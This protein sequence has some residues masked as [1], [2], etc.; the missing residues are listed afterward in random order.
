[1][2]VVTTPAFLTTRAGTTFPVA[3]PLTAILTDARGPMAGVPVTF[4]LPITGARATFPGGTSSVTVNTGSDGLA[5]AQTAMADPTVGAFAATIST[6]GATSTAVPMAAQY[7]LT[8][9]LPPFSGSQLRVTSATGTTPLKTSALLA[10]NTRLSDLAATA[11]VS[12]DRLQVRWRQVVPAGTTPPPWTTRAISTRYDTDMDFFQADLKASTLGWVK[13][14]TYEVN[15]RLLPAT[16]DP[17]PV[18]DALQ[19][20]FDLGSRS[21]RVQVK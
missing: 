9:F 10:D 14:K 7:A 17:Q 20:S 16:A 15:F 12:S 19:S 2:Q 3:T 5:T 18:G 13:G 1:M 21:A 8:P 11:L 4:T 6:E